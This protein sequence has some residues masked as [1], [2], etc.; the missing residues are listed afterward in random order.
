MN[1]KTSLPEKH[2]RRQFF[3]LP[4]CL[5]LLFLMF[6]A[7]A[8]TLV[9]FVFP[10]EAPPDFSEWVDCMLL[11][12]FLFV[13]LCL[14][15]AVLSLINRVAFGRRVCYMN[16][17]GLCYGNE[18]ILW[19]NIVKMEF[20]IPSLVYG[21]YY[22]AYVRVTLKNKKELEM[23]H[24]PFEVLLAV[25]RYAPHVKRRLDPIQWIVPLVIL[26]VTPLALLLI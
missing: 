4:L 7:Y 8:V 16:A 22:P 19:S 3:N 25:K 21:T 5:L 10:G 11:L 18:L 14:P 9:A 12:G 6:A 17:H 13:F 23:T 26:T 2:F 1:Q 20:S 15:L 24:A